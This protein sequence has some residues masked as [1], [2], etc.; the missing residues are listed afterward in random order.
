MFSGLRMQKMELTRQ[1]PTYEEESAM[2]LLSIHSI[3]SERSVLGSLLIDNSF[4]DDVNLLPSDFSQHSHQL[5]YETIIGM[6]NDDVPFDVITVFERLGDNN[7]MVGGLGYLGSL[8]NNLPTT[9]NALA[10]A[11]IVKNKATL[12]SLAR[13]GSELVQKA[14]SNEKAESIIDY[15]QAKILGFDDHTSS[16]V[17]TVTE[18]LPAVVDGID[19][20]FQSEDELVGI[21]TGFSDLDKMT[22]GLNNGDLIIVAGR[23]SMGKTSLSL[24][25]A[26]HAALSGKSALF[27]SMEMPSKQLVE[28]EISAI[29]LIDYTRIRSGKLEDSDWPRL[30]TAVGKLNNAPLMIDDSPALTVGQ[31]RSRARRT[32]KKHGLDL[33]VIDYLQLMQGSGNNRTEDIAEISRGLKSLAKELNIPVIAL[34]QLNRELEK[35]GNKRP[36]MS[37]LRDSGAIEQD[38][39]LIMF[40]YRD[41]VYNENS[42]D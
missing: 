24:N 8:V 33:I 2:E 27:F 38:A 41:E 14:H 30:T 16:D 31:V 4:L 35:R 7:V 20:R 23:P 36:I 19:E 42:S 37:D 25:I 39:D 1:R 18:L 11:N 10:Y 21:S 34:S 32:K 6:A 22:L 26:R 5:I 9:F 40:V 17:L 13:L 28:K 29:G 3:E 15:A 12:R